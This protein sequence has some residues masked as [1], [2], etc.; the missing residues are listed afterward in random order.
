MSGT[1]RT[2]SVA[3]TMV[4]IPELRHS[5][6]YYSK[7]YNIL[8]ELSDKGKQDAVE[9][10]AK[11]L[12]AMGFKFD[13]AF[14]SCLTRANQ[15]LQMILRELN[16]ETVPVKQHWRLN[17]RHY[18]ALTGFNKREMAEVYGDEQVQ[19]WRRS[20]NVPPPK[21]TERNPHYEAIRF[22]EKFRGIPNFPDTETL[23]ST[24][25]RVVSYW[26]ECIVPE[27]RDGKRVL[28]VAHGTSLRGLIK[29]IEG[30][31]SAVFGHLNL[32]FNDFLSFV[33]L[34]YRL[35]Q[36]ANNETELTEQHSVFL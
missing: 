15:T 27:V 18:G 1:E 5:V 7:R 14:T 13:V 20:Y 30:N 6:W 23:E 31:S 33:L 21:F 4:S 11:A 24:M 22:N 9:I 10:S 8:A 32:I 2:C 26:D 36:R 12:L 16:Q 29:H 3:G 17:E 35:E 28:I 19:V 34:Y 25:K